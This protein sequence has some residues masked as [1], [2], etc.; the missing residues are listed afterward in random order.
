MEQPRRRGP[1]QLIFGILRNTG[2]PIKKTHLYQAVNMNSQLFE[3]YL[4]L[5]SEKELIEKVPYVTASGHRITR[6]PY[7]YVITNK[8]KTFTELFEWTYDTLGWN[9]P[10]MLGEN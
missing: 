1:L 4:S 8:G 10:P 7:L 6:T 9:T 2:E 5:L 3:K